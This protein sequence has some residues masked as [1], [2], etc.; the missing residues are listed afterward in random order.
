VNVTAELTKF[1]FTNIDWS[2][3]SGKFITIEGEL[4]V[5]EKSTKHHS[6][7]LLAIVFRQLADNAEM[8]SRFEQASTFRQ[9][10]METEWL[11]KR[12]KFRNWFTKLKARL[13][14]FSFGV[15]GNKKG[16]GKLLAKTL[17]NFRRSGD[18]F[19]HG[20]YRWTSYYG[21]SWVW[22]ST[23]L[24]LILLLLFPIIY[25]QTQF[26]VCP[27]D[28]PI[29]ISLVG[30]DSNDEQ[31]RQNCRCS[32]TGLSFGEGIAHSLTTATLQN[33]DYR[34]PTTKKGEVV[35]ILE[36]IFAPLQAAL[37]ALALRRKFMR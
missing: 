29:T 33:V 19:I 24:L 28:K 26:Q 17:G 23:I 2:D 14:H 32:R 35:I 13:R 7:R 10:A 11:E 18:Y 34:K 1:N 8:N 36:K 25:T 22:A 3:E 4:S 31:M 20:L 16:R 5:I 9:M 15:K 12:A 6:R 21:E 37:L 27:K 30:C